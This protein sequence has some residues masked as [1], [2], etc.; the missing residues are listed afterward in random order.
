MT[1][2]TSIPEP[3]SNAPSSFHATPDLLRSAS[4]FRITRS[5]RFSPILDASKSQTIA[6]RRILADSVTLGGR[7]PLR[8]SGIESRS[9]GLTPS[10]DQ[11]RLLQPPI[12][13]GLT[14]ADRTVAVQCPSRGQTMARRFPNSVPAM[15]A[16]WPAM[17]Q[18]CSCHVQLAA[19]KC[20]GNV[21]AKGTYFFRADGTRPWHGEG[22]MLP[23][24]SGNW[25]VFLPLL[26]DTIS[27]FNRTIKPNDVVWRILILEFQHS[28]WSGNS[29]SKR[30]PADFGKISYCIYPVG[31]PG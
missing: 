24:R 4:G 19:G 30:D 15:S 14:E 7:D 26:A 21:P 8:L 1:H 13:G 11:I 20:P 17:S 27:L 12:V 2:P 29:I 23:R 5:V 25:R 3:R 10:P 22:A 28:A 16:Q 6:R 18:S 9:I 31:E